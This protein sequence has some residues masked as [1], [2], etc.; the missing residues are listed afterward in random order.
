MHVFMY[1]HRRKTVVFS[2]RRKDW[3]RVSQV[4]ISS[5]VPLRLQTGKPISLAIETRVISEIEI[6]MTGAE[7]GTSFLG[8]TLPQ[9][10]L[11]VRQLF[12]SEPVDEAKN[13]PFRKVMLHT[14]IHTYSIQFEHY[15]EPSSLELCCVDNDGDNWRSVKS[16]TTSAK[17]AAP[18]PSSEKYRP[19]FGNRAGGSDKPESSSDKYRS[20]FSTRGDK[21]RYT[22]LTYLHTYIH[23]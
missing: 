16:S 19:N 3:K 18:E 8:G 2:R 11:Q 20:S 6:E 21:S 22:I 12:K 5:R 13:I 4:F 1:I 10:L 14:Y 7:T 17:P 15:Y 9:P 23:K